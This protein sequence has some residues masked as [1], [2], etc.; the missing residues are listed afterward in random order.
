[1][2]RSFEP[3]RFIVCGVTCVLFRKSFTEESLS[4]LVPSTKRTWTGSL[5]EMPA[6][7]G[8]GLTSATKGPLD[9]GWLRLLYEATASK[10]A[11]GSLISRKLPEVVSTEKNCRLAPRPV[12]Q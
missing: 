7:S 5:G 10:G 1:L 3:V 2:T 8:N 6:A 11:F 9:L 4:A 12:C